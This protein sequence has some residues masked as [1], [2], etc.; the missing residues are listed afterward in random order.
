MI[1]QAQ[2]DKKPTV[3]LALG[4]G[5][6]RGYAH[7]GVIEVLQ[8]HGY[9]IIAL[10]G[11]SMGALVGG[12]YA[13]G[14]LK[15]FKDWATGLDQFDILRLLD[16]SITSPGAIRGEKVFSIV[17]E[18]IGDIAIEDLPIPYTAVATDLLRHKEIWFQEGPLHQA[19]RASVAIPSL[20]TPVALGDRLL[21]D[22]GLLNPLPIMPTVASHADLVVAVNLSWENGRTIRLQ[23]Q[24]PTARF[25]ERFEQW[26]TR[27]KHKTSKLFDKDAL[28]S[29]LAD[30]LASEDEVDAIKARNESAREAFLRDDWPKNSAAVVE[31]SEAAVVEKNERDDQNDP[32]LLREDGNKGRGGD[33]S[34]QLER[35]TRVDPVSPGRQFIQGD[36]VEADSRDDEIE[37]VLESNGQFSKFDIMNMAFETMQSSL[38]QYK[39]A[40]YPPD[41]LINIPKHVCKT[42]EYHK[43]PELIALGR[44]QAE[45]ALQAHEQKMDLSK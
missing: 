10:S 19:I 14:K 38:T 18:L 45:A 21:V 37:E 36:R 17:R 33:Q 39:L 34:S 23:P 40:G 30:G 42:F 28:Q 16:V 1:K 32:G 27:V 3:A 35:S 25:E 11:C 6:A 29:V 13:A 2:P 24:E 15:E 41:I 5:G 22:G 8:E 7:I 9:D 43:A 20:L 4:S 12:I 31:K 26:I 44:K